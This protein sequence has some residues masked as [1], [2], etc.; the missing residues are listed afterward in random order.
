MQLSCCLPSVVGSGVAGLA[1]PVAPLCA[2]VALTYPRAITTASRPRVSRRLLQ[3]PPGRE[4]PSTITSKMIRR[5]PDRIDAKRKNLIS[6]KRKQFADATYEPHQ[7]RHRLNF[8]EL[9]PTAEITLEQF[10]QWAIDRL[11]SITAGIRDAK[12]FG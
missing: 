4:T 3:Q 8:Y 6:H 11:R 5:N 7:Y 12:H 1:E 9:P 10:E 2:G